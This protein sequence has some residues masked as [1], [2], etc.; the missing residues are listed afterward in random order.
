MKRRVTLK[1]IAKATGVSVACVSLALRD[2][3]QIAGETKGRIREWAEKLGYRPDP[4]LSA[5][6]AYRSRVQPEHFRS[7][8]ALV[9]DGV[10]RSGEDTL[11]LPMSARARELG[12]EP[13]L[14]TVA[15]PACEWIPLL[16][17]LRSRGIRGVF[18]APRSRYDEK[19]PSA[20]TGEFCFVTVGYSVRLDGIHRVSTNQYLDMLR[21]VRELRPLGYQRPGLW[22]PETADGRVN[23]QFS[24]GY[25]AAFLPQETPPA[26]ILRDAAPS[27]RKLR[28]W[29]RH[30]HLDAVIGLSGHLPRLGEAGFKIPDALGFSSYDWHGGKSVVGITGMDY[31]PRALSAG[32]VDVLHAALINNRTGLSP[33]F[34]LTLHDARFIP[35]KTTRQA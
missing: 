6:A 23:H 22:V 14:F 4:A 27:R 21:H 3:P 19:F 30:H 33:D 7:V 10:R 25:F 9:T 26:P 35:G 28:D 24:A 20:P 11:W 13:A 16:R 31:R 18:L 8:L 2:S 5:L 17:V 29:V 12:Y 15:N 1:D 34:P 32:A